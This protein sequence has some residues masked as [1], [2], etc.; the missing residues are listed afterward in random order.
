MN[1]IIFVDLGYNY[2]LKDYID[3]PVHQELINSFKNKDL[4]SKSVI[5]V[6]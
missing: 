3:H 6:E 2:V 4:L 1:I 5:D